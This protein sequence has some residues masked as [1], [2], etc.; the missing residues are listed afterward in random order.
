MCSDV[1]VNGLLALEALRS[2]PYDVVFCTKVGNLDNV[3]NPFLIQLGL[4]G[5]SY[6]RGVWTRGCV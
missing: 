6:A 4:D 1:A 5:P 2:H 3:R